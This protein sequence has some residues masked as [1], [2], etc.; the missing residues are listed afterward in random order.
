[1]ADLFDRLIGGLAAR[2]HGYVTREQLLA[3]GVGS[4][5]IKYRVKIGRLIP[6]YAGVYAVGYVRRDPV[7]CA[8]AAVLAC[9]DKGVLSHGSAATCGDSASTGT[10]RS[11]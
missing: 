4:G 7:S 1:M 5:A 6:V 10:R 8:H 2:Q 3:L 9:G 11:R